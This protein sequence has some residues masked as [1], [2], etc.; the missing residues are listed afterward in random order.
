MWVG[1]AGLRT[2]VIDE[3]ELEQDDEEDKEGGAEEHRASKLPPL[4]HLQQRRPSHEGTKLVALPHP[5]VCHLHISPSPCLPTTLLIRLL[6][7]HCIRSG[8]EAR[9]QAAPPPR[10][11]L[12]LPS[13]PLRRELVLLA[14]APL[15]RVHQSG[16]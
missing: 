10:T 4:A 12:T 9:Q 6:F 2:R 1:E 16:E 3:Q 5:L 14:L 8:L 11:E 13:F 15:P 7:S